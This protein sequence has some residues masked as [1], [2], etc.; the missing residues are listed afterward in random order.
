MR[1]LLFKANKKMI[2][3]KKMLT[4]T[5]AAMA[6]IFMS[7]LQPAITYAMD[8]DLNLPTPGGGMVGQIVVF[9]FGWLAVAGIIVA[10]IG[11]IMFAI[12]FTSQDAAAKANA[13]KV[14]IAGAAVMAVGG[15]IAGLAIFTGG[16]S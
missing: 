11:G 1:Q 3:A 12:S 7:V 5:A 8:I 10:G 9:I 4:S 16:G 6:A 15:S 14:I 13:I 2:K